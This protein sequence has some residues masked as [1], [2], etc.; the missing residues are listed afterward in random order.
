MLQIRQTISRRAKAF[1][2]KN[3]LGG[4]ALPDFEIHCKERSAGQGGTRGKTDA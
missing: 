1:L 2:K 4:R 3:Q